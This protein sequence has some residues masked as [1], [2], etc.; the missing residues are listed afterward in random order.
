M[1]NKE[2]YFSLQKDKIIDQ[3]KFAK[4]K[5]PYYQ[6][7]LKNVD[8]SNIKNYEDFYNNIP[9]IEGNEI[10]KNPK[11]FRSDYSILFTRHSSS[12]TGKPKEVFLTAQDLEVWKEKG[13]LT[14]TPYFK[15]GMIVAFSKR[16]EKYYLSGLKEAVEF[17]GGK[18]LT[19]NPGKISELISAIKKADIILDYAE[20]IYYIS[21]KLKDLDILFNKKITL[22][23]TGNILEKKDIITIKENFKRVGVD[24]E[25]FSEYSATE[26]GPIGC[27]DNIKNNNFKIIYEDIVFVEVI[28]STN[29]KP[30]SIGEIVVTA[31][32][33]TGSIFIRYKLGDIGKLFFENNFPIFILQQRK[34][35]IKVASV[36]L[37]PAQIFRI[38]RRE[39]NCPV[40]CKINIKQKKYFSN[41]LINIASE[42]SFDKPIIKKLKELLLK[43]LELED[44]E[45]IT[46]KMQI[47]LQKRKLKDMELRKGFK[48]EMYVYKIF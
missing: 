17:S 31:L 24:A 30:S 2:D 46:A 7:K 21:D 8:L 9:L 11:K 35:G 40:Y 10:L 4:E 45:G 19:F 29:N 39:L 32:N 12:T 1:L 37:S 41:I 20:M 47:K 28:N 3:L 23:Y 38:V 14:I 6:E 18:T 33:R 36:F 26:I 48:I 22:S 44:D 13:R 5:V 27:S 25:V 15:P 43:K 42:K 34:Q 16:K